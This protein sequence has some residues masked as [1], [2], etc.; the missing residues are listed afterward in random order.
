MKPV[1]IPKNPD[2]SNQQTMTSEPLNSQEHSRYR[3]IMG[4]L[5]CLAMKTR[6][7]I[8][9]AATLLASHT[10]KPRKHHTMAA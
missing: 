7:D 8:C 3:Q 5:M 6:L 4:T 10:L 1:G 9:M 2:I